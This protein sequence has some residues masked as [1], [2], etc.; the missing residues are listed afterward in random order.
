MNLAVLGDGMSSKI[1]I[2]GVF[3]KAC[4]RTYHI[5]ITLSSYLLVYVY[6]DDMIPTDID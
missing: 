3:E 5:S 4:Q 6:M 1:R 2:E